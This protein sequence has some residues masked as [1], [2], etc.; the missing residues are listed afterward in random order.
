MLYSVSR[1]NSKTGP[2][3]TVRSP[4]AT[5]P[6]TCSL[7]GN[8]C[9]AENAPLAWHWD[10]K[11]TLKFTDVLRH[12]RSMAISQPGA[13]WRLWEAGDFPHDHGLIRFNDIVALT[14][15][16]KGLRGFGFTHHDPLRA[17]NAFAIRYAVSRGLTINLS[18]DNVV[19]ADT[20]AN[21][22]IA[23]VAVVMPL[24]TP[25]VSLTPEGRKVVLCPAEIRREGNKPITCVQCMLCW[26]ADRKY[27]IGFTAHGARKKVASRIATVPIDTGL[28]EVLS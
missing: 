12:L 27:L 14:D 4:R 6:D 19:L 16:N 20:Y 28:Q 8:G 3:L 23:P 11:H 1:G 22:G 25:K 13:G 18:A 21:L 2:M 17:P 10:S 15:A 7:K 24:G 9:Y 26:K 5:C